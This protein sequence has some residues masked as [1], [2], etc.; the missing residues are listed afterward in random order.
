MSLIPQAGQNQQR[1]LEMTYHLGCGSVIASSICRNPQLKSNRCSMIC[2]IALISPGIARMSPVRENHKLSI[3]KAGQS[4][5]HREIRPAPGV[6][7]SGETIDSLP[8]VWHLWSATYISSA[9]KCRRQTSTQAETKWHPPLTHSPPGWG[10]RWLSVQCTPCAHLAGVS[11]QYI[12]CNRTMRHWSWPPAASYGGRRPK[13][14]DT[15][16]HQNFT[17][18]LILMHFCAQICDMNVIGVHLMQFNYPCAT[19]YFLP[20][21]WTLSTELFV[22]FICN[23]KPVSDLCPKSLC[24]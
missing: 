12:A 3:S 19:K 8:L 1:I 18:N 24:N 2:P 20:S 5:T 10:F 23:L 13:S 14:W 4:L 16:L 9:T 21:D 17:Q 22:A 15:L 11:F 6:R 7:S